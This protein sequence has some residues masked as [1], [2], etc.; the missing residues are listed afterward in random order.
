MLAPGQSLEFTVRFAP[1]G[2]GMFSASLRAET[3]VVILRGTALPGLSVVAEQEG[4]LRPL[5]AGTTLDF[6]AAERGTAVR[7]R[8]LLENRG[9]EPVPVPPLAIAGGAFRLE[10]KPGSG[11]L[12]GPG[13]ALALDVVFEPHAAGQ[14]E[15]A[16]EIGMRRIALLGV[17]REPALPRPALEV[18]RSRP[19]SG[20]Q[21]RVTVRLAEPPLGRGTG[22]LRVELEPAAGGFPA[23]PAVVFSTGSRSVRFAVAEGEGAARFAN[24]AFIAVQTGTTAGTLVLTAELGES[25]AQLRLP[26]A[27]EPARLQSAHAIRRGN[28]LEVRVTG[29]DNHR[30]VSQLSFSFFGRDGQAVPASPV[31]VDAAAAFQRYFETAELGGAFVLSALFP[32]AGDAALIASVE[33]E[34]VSAA[35]ATRS[36]R[37][38]F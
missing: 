37:M 26:I 10:G 27:A 14:W 25:I 1:A 34:I 6:G 13:E 12:V 35:G 2:P 20:E 21:V 36:P 22:T 4:A 19:G 3:V 7:R 31:R 38:P 29:F 8:V 24:E 23:D 9:G 5:A 17:A 18:D 33:L 15:G 32:V 28:Q 16:L 11:A 30:S